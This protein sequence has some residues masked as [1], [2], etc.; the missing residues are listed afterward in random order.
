MKTLLLLV[1]TKLF[2]L[3]FL[4]TCTIILAN[5][6]VQRNDPFSFT[7]VNENIVAKP[8]NSEVAKKKIATQKMNL[9]LQENSFREAGESFTAAV[10]SDLPD[11]APFSTA[12]FTGNGFLPNEKCSIEG[13]ES[14]EA[15]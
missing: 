8:E 11:Y 13:E 7:E 9:Q 6:Y 10:T 12:T 3:A 15:L 5:N 1:R 4:F 14:Y 2:L